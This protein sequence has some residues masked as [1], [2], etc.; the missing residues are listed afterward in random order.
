M[1]RKAILIESSHIRGH[2]D[3][4]GARA[5][6]SSLYSFLDSP[7]GGWWFKHEIEIL[8]HPTL[9]DLHSPIRNS[10]SADYCLVYFAGEGHHVMGQ[11]VQETR[12]CINDTEEESVLKLNPGNDK[13][14]VIADTCRRITY[15]SLLESLQLS[16]RAKAAARAPDG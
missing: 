8:H 13:C 1:T 15:L 4:P 9:Q 6:I 3:L 12:V 5:D 11:G 16:L 10:S 14:L 7:I 2:D